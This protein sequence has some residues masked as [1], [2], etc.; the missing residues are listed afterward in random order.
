MI[1]I[2]NKTS[3]KTF[4]GKRSPAKKRITIESQLPDTQLVKTFVEWT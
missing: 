2:A 4:K 1:C 3:I